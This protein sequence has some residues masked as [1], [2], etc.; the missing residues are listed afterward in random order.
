MES[1]APDPSRVR[2]GIHSLVSP[3]HLQLA[4]AIVESLRAQNCT[5]GCDYKT[6]LKAL[7]DEMS[8]GFRQV[9]GTLKEMADRFSEGNMRFTGFEF[10]VKALEEEKSER[11]ETLKLMQEALRTVQT[12]QITMQS[13]SAIEKKA[14]SSGLKLWQALLIGAV[15]AVGGSV[16]IGAASGGLRALLGE[17]ATAQAPPKSA[18]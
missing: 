3:D 12:A 4:A 1:M 11:K 5:P 6:D 9:H 18:P 13:T 10:R 7:R 16:G 15:T 17:P 14:K 8:G 2:S